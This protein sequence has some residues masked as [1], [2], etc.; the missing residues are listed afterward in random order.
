MTAPTPMNWGYF[1][2][3]FDSGLIN[4]PALCTPAGA[5]GTCTTFRLR[6][7]GHL[8]SLTAAFTSGV[9]IASV[10]SDGNV[11]NTLIGTASAN[12]AALMPASSSSL[13]SGTTGPAWQWSINSGGALSIVSGPP[14]AAVTAGTSTVAGTTVTVQG[15]WNADN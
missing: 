7:I 13:S 11:T 2:S 5:F 9:A 8:V 6:R 4:D 14:G 3:D 12:L 15:T 1:S 10:A